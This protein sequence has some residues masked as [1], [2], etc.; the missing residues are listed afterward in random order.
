[1]GVDLFFV[2]S[3]FLITS[4]LIAEWKE[5]GTISFGAFF[6]RRALRLL[7]AMVVMLTVVTAALAITGGRDQLVWVFFSVSY[8]VNVASIIGGDIPAVSLQHMWSLSQEEQF[9]LVWPIALLF[10]LRSRVRP[11]NVAVVLLAITV[12]IVVWRVFLGVSLASPGYLLYAP[13]TRSLGLLLGCLA[14]VLFS[15][16][17][18]TQVPLALATAMLMPAGMAV[19]LLGLTSRWD[20]VVLVPIFCA[21]ATVALL[22]CVLHPRW[23]FARL[24]DRSW[25]RGLGKI[26]YALYLW[27]WPLYFAFGWIVGL[28]LSLL[29]ACLSYRFVEQPF[30]RRRYREKDLA[31]RRTAPTTPDVGRRPS[32]LATPAAWSP[33]TS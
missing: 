17:L 8:V 20:A 12:V 25:L 13:E 31:S 33:S 22:A 28:P 32:T 11:Q 9:Y 16:G 15:Y 18:V 5:H 14:G 23:W 27:H 3:G 19:A 24:V 30:L 10:L 6:R 1:L 26:S 7:P 29:V 2:L 21:A 4:L